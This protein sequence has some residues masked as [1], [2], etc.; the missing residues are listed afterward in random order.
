VTDAMAPDVVSA[1]LARRFKLLDRDGNG[2]LEESDYEELVRR[3]TAAFGRDIDTAPGSTLRAA[4]LG[5]WSAMRSTMDTDGDGRISEEEFLAT[6]R[7]SVVDQNDG[8]EGVIQPVAE[9]VLAVCDVD[10]DGMLDQREVTTML[11]AYGVPAAEAGETFARLDHDHDGRL[12]IQEITTAAREFYC[13][14]NDDAPGNWFYG[15]P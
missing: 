6:V 11:G 8:F 4:Y 1:K 9:A 5:L 10:G 14:T 2:Y 13:S 15:R 3:L 7:D 12:T